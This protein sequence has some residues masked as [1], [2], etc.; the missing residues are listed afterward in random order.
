MAEKDFQ[1]KVVDL[2]FNREDSF[3]F[4]FVL[5]DEDS[6]AA[7]DLTGST[8][9]FTAA[10]TPD[11]DGGGA[12]LF[13]LTENNTPG[14]AGVVEFLPSQANMDQPQATYFY[15]LEWTD[16]SGRVRTVAKGKFIIGPQIS[17]AN[18]P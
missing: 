10:D 1:A 4:Q 8:F 9:L 15:D 12:Q 18:P 16:G 17:G 13:Q 7:L 14:V 11:L 6:G 5:T 3:P 2:K